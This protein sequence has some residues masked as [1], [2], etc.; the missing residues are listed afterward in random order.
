MYAYIE[1]FA[2]SKYVAEIEQD[3]NYRPSGAPGD[4]DAGSA[5]RLTGEEVKVNLQHFDAPVSSI[6]AR[7]SVG[8]LTD[9]R[10]SH[11]CIEI[12]KDEYD[13]LLA[14]S[15]KAAADNDEKETAEEIAEI[16]TLLAAADPQADIPSPE[17]AK[18]RREAYNNLYNEGGE[19]YVPQIIDSRQYEMLT[20]RL[21]ELNAKQKEGAR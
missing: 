2:G 6:R 8:M 16:R 7:E 15:E 19:G 14:A 21:A 13:L 11:I 9:N 12:S 18:A 5:M 20:A 10:P 17:E 4:I 1:E 3:T